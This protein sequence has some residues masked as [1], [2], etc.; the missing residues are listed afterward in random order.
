MMEKLTE[1]ERPESEKRPST[2]QDEPIVITVDDR[3]RRRRIKARSP[4]AVTKAAGLSAPP[5]RPVRASLGPRSESSVYSQRPS[6][7]SSSPQPSFSWR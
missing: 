6:S 7:H 2:S 1:S 5:S 3:N 4:L